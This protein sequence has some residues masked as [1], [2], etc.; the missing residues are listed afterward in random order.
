MRAAMIAL[1]VWTAVPGAQAAEPDRGR[2]Y[3]RGEAGTADIHGRSEW[4]GWLAGRVGRAFGASRAFSADAGLALSG[5]D[6]DYVS[7]TAGFEALFVPNARVSPF[8]RVEAG[9]LAEP[10]FSGLVLGAGGG[11][12][13]RVSR[14]FALRAGAT[15][16]THGNGEGGGGPVHAGLALEYRW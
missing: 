14:R 8:V 12:A 13:V 4:D 15:W 6:E 10:E 3:L 16:S 9:L 2:W 7:A 5:A 11:L 1:C